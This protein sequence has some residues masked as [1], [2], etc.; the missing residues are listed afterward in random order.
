VAPSPQ[1][2]EELIAQTD[3]SI[4]RTPPR[5]HRRKAQ[6]AE[7]TRETTDGAELIDGEGNGLCFPTGRLWT[8]DEIR[9]LAI[10]E[11]RAVE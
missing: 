2:D 3:F 1:A 6:G 8:M 7:A 9:G 10:P 11:I 4:L 5:A